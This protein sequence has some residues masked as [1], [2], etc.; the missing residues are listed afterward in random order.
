M[1]NIAET[2]RLSI[3]CAARYLRLA[4]LSPEVL[5]AIILVHRPIAI[6]MTDLVRVAARPWMEQVEAVFGGAQDGKSGSTLSRA[7]R[8]NTPP[9]SY[10]KRLLLGRHCFWY[11]SVVPPRNPLR[12]RNWTGPHEY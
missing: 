11:C 10:T 6:R 7:N 3:S 4:C 5:E 1:N 12:V 9:A 2:Q 8:E